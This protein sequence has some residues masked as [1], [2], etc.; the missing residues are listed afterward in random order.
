MAFLTA[1]LADF[2]AAGFAAGF[3]G[4]GAMAASYGHQ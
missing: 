3:F 2:F 4:V 1:G